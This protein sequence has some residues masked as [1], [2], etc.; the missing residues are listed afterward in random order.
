M[1]RATIATSTEPHASACAVPRYS[2]D[3]Q[4]RGAARAEARGSGSCGNY[5]TRYK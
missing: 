5:E 2:C 3:E 1:S 4:V